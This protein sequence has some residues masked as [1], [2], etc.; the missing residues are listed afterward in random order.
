M[1]KSFDSHA[2]CGPE[3]VTSDELGDPGHLALR[4]WVN[5]ELRQDS[6]TADLIFGC[7]A[8]I[9]YLTTAFPLEPGHDHRDR[10]PGRRGSRR[11]PAAVPG[12]RRQVRIDI[13][14]IGE[15]VNPVVQG[16]GP[17]RS[18]STTDGGSVPGS[19]G[20]RRAR[21]NGGVPDDDR[22]S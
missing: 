11:S 6:T 3:L 7:A 13:E 4:T 15:L 5:D 1:G 16:G 8:M 20:R 10:D 22:Q 14:G 19:R 17:C 18:G 2:P 21:Q 9:E 12:R